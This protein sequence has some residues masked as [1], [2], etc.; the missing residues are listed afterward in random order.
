MILSRV[1]GRRLAVD[2]R[3]WGLGAGRRSNR[4]RIARGERPL[5]RLVQGS[6]ACPLDA[7]RGRLIERERSRTALGRHTGDL[8]Y[9]LPSAI[10]RT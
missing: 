4:N 3:A 10:G 2:W 6:I 9:R 5:Q 8:V 7:A 1:P